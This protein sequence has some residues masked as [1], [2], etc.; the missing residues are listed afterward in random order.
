VDGVAAFLH[1]GKFVR[2]RFGLSRGRSVW[3]S[4]SVD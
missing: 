1:R 2:V 3:V 4:S